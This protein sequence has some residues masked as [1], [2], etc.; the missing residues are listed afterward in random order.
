MLATT[1]RLKVHI[2]WMIRKDLSQVLEIENNNSQL[3]SPI[4]KWGKQDFLAILG[5]NN[6][7]GMVAE[8]RE[9][10][11]GFFVYN[12][13]PDKLHVYNMAVDKDYENQGIGVQL[14][15]ML[16]SKLK[17]G[18]RTMLEIDVREYSL[19]AQLFLKKRGFLAVETVPGW[20]EQPRQEDAYRFRFILE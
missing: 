14:V 10:I 8:Y 1:K 2:R 15:D 5:D 13:Q 3:S 9:K 16:K 19:R 11:L 12:L 6:N 18:R 17:L 7:I 4:G 20:Y